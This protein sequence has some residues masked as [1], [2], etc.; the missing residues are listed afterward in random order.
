MKGI[1]LGFSGNQ[2]VE[3]PD[4]DFYWRTLLEEQ[5]D[6]RAEAICLD[7]VHWFGLLR[8][9]DLPQQTKDS[10]WSA[11]RK[12]EAVENRREALIGLK[13]ARRNA[14][15]SI[16]NDTKKAISAL[17]ASSRMQIYH[18]MNDNKEGILREI[19][20]STLIMSN[21]GHKFAKLV[22]SGDYKAFDKISE[23]LK[24][25]IEIDSATSKGG[26]FT[27]DG[28]VLRKFVDLHVESR[29]LPTKKEL[30]EKSG[31]GRDMKAAGKSMKKLGLSGLPTKSFAP[32]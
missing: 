8:H 3:I 32:D 24:N 30:R 5:A 19:N 10:F 1:K 9:I 18:M 2:D 12:A 20:F 16:L 27:T 26:E 7:G 31:L 15:V 29:S 11:F 4:I 14:E 22:R 6:D 25:G 13:Q 23:I 17:D 28:I 21:I